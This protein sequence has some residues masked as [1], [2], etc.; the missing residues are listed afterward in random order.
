MSEQKCKDGKPKAANVLQIKTKP[1]EVEGTSVARASFDPVGR[2]ANLATCIV[3]NTFVDNRKPTIMASTEALQ[4]ILLEAQAGD[5]NMASRLLASQAI[6]LDT[7]FTELT[8][9]AVSN[10]GH[11]PDAVERYLRMALRAQSNCRTTVE[12]LT[13]LHQPREQTV[14]HVHVNEGGQAVVAEHF[15]THSEGSKNAKSN[16]QSHATRTAGESSAMLGA[17]PHGEGVPIS[18]SEGAKAVQDARRD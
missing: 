9:R 5:M 8:G 16:K 18:S 15:H 7:L 11:Y 14:R 12:A 10:L 1:G 17:D 2:H 3:G 4:S 13:K 6:T